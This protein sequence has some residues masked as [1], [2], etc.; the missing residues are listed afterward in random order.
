MKTLPLGTRC[1]FPSSAST[2]LLLASWVLMALAGAA[3]S[4]S[5]SVGVQ[6]MRRISDV[7]E[8][9]EL[10]SDS[11]EWIVSD[12][13]R[14]LGELRAREAIPELQRILEDSAIGPYA[15]YEAALALSRMGAPG[16]GGAMHLAFERAGHPEERY[17]LVVAVSAYCDEAS[18]G[19]LEQVMSDSDIYV[20]R[21]ARKGY[22]NCLSVLASSPEEPPPEPEDSTPPETREVEE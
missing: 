13:A 12:A 17:W 20:A 1:S 7:P 3:C 2:L 10:L 5:P 15:R 8:L 22:N 11:H 21:A 19:L 9:I 18:M 4:S 16:L 6:Q 14:R